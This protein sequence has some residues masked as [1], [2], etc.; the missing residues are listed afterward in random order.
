MNEWADMK[1]MTLPSR[2]IIFTSS[3]GGLRPSTIS[4]MKAPHNNEYL[5]VSW[6]KRYGSLEPE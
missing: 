6:E 5:R 1:Q 2:D 3:P 4:V